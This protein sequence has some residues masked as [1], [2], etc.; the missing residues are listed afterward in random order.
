V[1]RSLPAGVHH[2]F[3]TMPGGTRV[4]VGSYDLRASTH[5]N[6]VIVPGPDGRPALG[7]VD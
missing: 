1:Y 5:P 2:I 3:C 4:E 6:L 7:H